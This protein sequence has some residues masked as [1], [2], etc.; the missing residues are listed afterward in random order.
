MAITSR[1]SPKFQLTHFTEVTIKRFPPG[2]MVK[3]KWVKGIPFNV[4]VE[5]NVQPARHKDLMMMTESDR[6]KE[7][8]KVFSR[9]VIRTAKEG[10]GAYDSDVV[11]WDGFEYKVMKSRNFSMGVLDHFEVLAARTPISALPL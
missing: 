6:T 3:G 8:I 2:E 1:T 9:D 11:L 5:A 4:V 10:D 7:W